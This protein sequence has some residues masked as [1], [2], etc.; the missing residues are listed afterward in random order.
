MQFDPTDNGQP[1]F[2]DPILPDLAYDFDAPDCAEG[3]GEIVSPDRAL[4]DCMNLYGRV[5][6]AYLISHTG[7]TALSLLLHDLRGAVFQDPAGFAEET[8]WSPEGT[9]LLRPQYLSGNVAAKYA[10]AQEMNQRFPGRFQANLDALREILPWAP[11][12]D[13]IRVSLGATWIP[14]S[15][16]RDF[17]RE[18]FHLTV[19]PEVLFNTKLAKWI[20]N[21]PGESHDTVLARFVY[22]TIDLSGFKI[23]EHTMNAR[24]V[25]VF[26]HVHHYDGKVE[27]A[28]N[29]AKTVEAQEKQRTIIQ[30]FAAWI[31]EDSKRRAVIREAYEQA[32]VGFVGPKYDGTFL[33]LPGLNPAVTLYPYQRNAIARILLSDGNTLLAHPVGA[34][35]TYEIIVSAHELLRMGLSRKTMIVVPN[36]ILQSV[37]EMHRCLYPDDAFTVISPQTFRPKARDRL[38]CAVRD[39]EQACVYMACSAFDM[40]RMSVDY[41]ITKKEKELRSLRFS[42]SQCENRQERSQLDAEILRKTKT[43]EKFVATAE[44]QPWLSFDELG[45]DTLYVD[46]AHNY[47]NIDIASRTDNIVGLHGQGSRKSVEMLEKCRNVRRVV[48]ATGT[49]MTNSIADLFVF[50][51]YLQPH[52]L[53][54]R[55][56]DSFDMWINTFGERETGFEI[57][58]DGNRLRLTT[59]FSAFHNLTELMSIFSVVCD[60]VDNDACSAELPAFRGHT[61]V[62]GRKSQAQEAYFRFLSERTNQIRAH[63]LRRDEDNLLRVTTQGRACALDIRL[64]DTGEAGIDCGGGDTADCKI[65]MCAREVLRLYQAYP[66]TCQLVFSDIGTPKDGFN[67][68]DA[69]RDALTALGVPRGEIAFVHDAVSEEERSALFRDMNSGAVRVAVGSTQKLGIGVNVQEKLIALHHLSV[70]WRPSDMVQREGRILRSGNTCPEVFIYRYITEGTFDSYSWQLLENKQRFISS[71][72]SGASA[73]RDREDISG[74]VLSYAEVKALAIGNPL[75]RARV[76]TANRLDRAMIAFRMRQKQLAN[77]RA[78]TE[79]SPARIRR[80]NGVCANIQNDIARYAAAKTSVPREEREAFGDELLFALADNVL[81]ERERVFD[82]YQGFEIVLPAYMEADQPHVLVRSGRGSVYQVEMKDAKALG[83]AMRIDH[84]LEH[85]PE[86]LENVQTQIEAERRQCGDAYKDLE[87]GNPYQDTV[88]ELSRALAE[89]DARLAAEEENPDGLT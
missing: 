70:P 6:R 4:V 72:L 33:Q 57:D 84:L 37:A 85:L 42:A 77:L 71:F 14:A 56:N 27:S 50:Q 69:L 9:W 26:D 39:A 11:D 21:V 2:G 59:R 81:A 82:S 25:K 31:D 80:L 8:R 41:W 16:Y 63:Q 83:C 75:I 32:Y 23:I 5:D 55:R 12:Q 61:D 62:C 67:V 78:F 24:T 40:I 60:F 47:K 53:R 51:T 65:R 34:G 79:E 73:S 43:L 3:D 87:Q 17:I 89:I 1:V 20:V 7:K 76:E 30:R 22:G 48:F 19:E 52:E 10:L 36:H 15:I 66:G 38:L 49:P 46:E 13:E 54:Y 64:V 29:R 86:R 35:K 74:A 88:D 18:L 68:Y 44:D 58:V 45:I 28:V